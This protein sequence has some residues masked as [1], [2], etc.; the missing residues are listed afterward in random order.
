MRYASIRS[1]D[2][3]N[4]EGVGIALFV[5]GCHAHCK[6]CFNQDT[7][8]FN[9]GKE[10]NGTVKNN[11]F[12]LLDKSY[13]TRCSILGGEPLAEENLEDVLNLVK[14]IRELYPDKTIWLY[15]G[16]TYE[17]LIRY[18]LY[19]AP[20]QREENELKRKEILKNIDILVDGEYKD[21]LR[22]VTL[23][24]RGSS[25]QRVIDVQESL[26]QNKVVL[27]CD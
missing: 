11:F 8:D 22:D 13:I 10:W 2:I 12:K 21:D 25:N 17:M 3:S 20:C 27:Y 18:I 15:T 1:M 14:E 7:W 6:N 24:W 4:G 5:Q 9:S 23:K 16:Y 19:F 26:K